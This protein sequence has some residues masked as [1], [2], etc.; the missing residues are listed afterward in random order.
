MSDSENPQHNPEPDPAL[1]PSIG[2]PANGGP[3]NG[4]PQDGAQ[5]PAPPAVGAP[6]ENVQSPA[7]SAIEPQED[8]QSPALS[9]IEPQ[10]ADGDTQQTSSPSSPG[11]RPERV[12]RSS[13]GRKGLWAG[14]AV[15]CVAVG[16]AGSV[17]GAH[18]VARSDGSE[19]R[20]TFQQGS[21]AIASTLKLAIQRQEELTVA[22]ATFFAAN[23]KA[24][25]A[26]FAAWVT[27]ARTLHRYP[28][29]DALGLM[30]AP[31]APVP[32]HPHTTVNASST[33]TS[34]EASSTSVDATPTPVSASSDTTPTPIDASSDASSTPIEESDASPTP[35]DVSSSPLPP[36]PPPVHVPPALALARDTGLSVYTPEPAGKRSALAVETPVYRG[37]VTPRSVFGRRAASVGWLR[38]VLV[39]GA[40]LQQALVGHP[41]YAVNLGYHG[42]SSNRVGAAHLLF[43]SGTPQTGAQSTTTSLHD[44]WTVT[45]FGAPAA[46]GVL[47]DGD[48]LAVLVAGIL[49]S[50]LLGLLVFAL[51]TRHPPAPAPTPAP[52]PK[53]AKEI[54]QPPKEDLYD[55]L[56]GLPNRTLTLDRAERMVARAGRD[57]GMLA[58]ALFVDIDRLKDVNEKLG[59]AAGDQLLKIVGERLGEVVRAGDTVGRLDGDEFVVLVESA[60]RGVR[61]DS[62]AQR[63]IE[64]L[65]KPIELDGFGP[66]FVLTASIGVAFGRYATPEDLLRDAHLALASAKAAGKDRYTLFNANMR[67]VIEGRA[68]LEAEL[69]TALQEQQFF[70]LYQPIYDLRTRRVVALEA[71]VRW[72]H[73]TQGVLAPEDFIPLS[74]DTGLIVPIGRWMLEA[75]C[76]RAAAWDVA[77]HR[78]GISVKVSAH[79]LNRD[80]FA[81][82]VRR[83]LQQ[84]GIEPSLLTLEIA[85]NT[86][87]RDI[88]AA[89]ER[90]REIKQLGVRIA[91]DDFGSG[92]Y[93]HH[94][95]LRQMPIDSLRVDRGSL[96][97]SEDEAYRSW[98]LEAILVVGREHSLTVIA[99]GI[100][101]H[102]QLGTLQAIGC[103]MAQGALLGQPT[104]ADAIDG[105]FNAALPA[106]TPAPSSLSH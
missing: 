5:S 34:T 45:S 66:S 89:T 6:Q 9:A 47:T 75:A 58:G 32:V 56:T 40:V 33:S 104:P 59:K 62:L 46:A 73:P 22:A 87:M 83:A 102:E 101:T 24:T 76:S 52:K 27:W 4:A 106:V 96:A 67:T 74:E 81:T 53:A 38:E 20:V 95:E 10:S 12:K 64:A 8:V 11:D 60:A 15:L 98:L 65:H 78:L 36:P 93:A 94:S 3:V 13:Q 82:D 91:I 57:S 69:N 77:G 23:P 105:L 25:H 84:S 88:A 42:A 80:G 85:E 1:N 35:I 2:G 16:T 103:P 86:V 30:P 17:L 37:N 49:L 7:P 72:Q 18:A 26:E 97:A 43:T 90:L 61:L 63:M 68:V 99:T 19:A 31:P 100:E 41:G 55:A 39:P 79:Q 14:L 28:E 50:A 44:G 92:G 48:A 54:D 21:A 51:G 70:M 71:Q 29:L